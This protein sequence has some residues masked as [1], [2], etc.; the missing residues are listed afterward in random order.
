[1]LLSF[2]LTPCVLWQSYTYCIYKIFQLLQLD[3]HLDAFSLLKGKEKMARMVRAQ[4][5]PIR[6]IY[7]TISPPLSSQ[8]EIFRKICA[9]LGWPFLPS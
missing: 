4:G 9:E 6:T 2:R 1:M 8:D 5:L 7:A 3:E